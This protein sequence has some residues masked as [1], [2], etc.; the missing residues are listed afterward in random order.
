MAETLSQYKS[1]LTPEEVDQA[2]HN[3]AQLDD[4]IA[5]AKQ[6][7]EQAQGYAESI[8]PEQ[9]APKSH[10]AAAD[11][12]GA[13]TGSLYGHV[14]LSDTASSSD[15][16]GGVAATPKCVQNAVNAGGQVQTLSVTSASPY[17]TIN[18]STTCYKC[19]NLLVLLIS[20]NIS[21]SLVGWN[22]IATISGDPKALKI[23]SKVMTVA[24]NDQTAMDAAIEGNTI[25]VSA[26]SRVY[27]QNYS[28]MIVAF[29][30]S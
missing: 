16:S 25:S 29:C 22:D 5:Q 26:S 10:A 1:S 6:Y 12:Y 9:F 4:G 24:N 27:G 7:A 30:D 3:I 18:G 23:Y 11:T 19:A 8:N 21:G 20:L 2:L 28:G 14:Q 17:V 13:A 15:A